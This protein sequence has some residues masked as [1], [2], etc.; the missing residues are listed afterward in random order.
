MESFILKFPPDTQFSDEEFFEFCVANDSLRIERNSQGQI[1]VMSPSGSKT[2]NLHFRIYN[3]L[4]RWYDNHENLG[5]LFDA[6]A[7][8]TL[9][10]NSVLAPDVAF[11]N[12]E[13]WESLTDAQQKKFAPLTP[14]FV[15]EVRSDSDS[16]SQLKS[17]MESW[18]RNG[19]QLA[20][21]IDPVEKKA[22]IY[23]P[24]EATLT[25]DNFNTVLVGEHVLPEFELFL[26]KLL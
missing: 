2:G 1:I 8:F 9:P 26:S 7:G 19:C 22:Y 25:V 6:S 13:R 12:K 15:I 23:K 20:W 18:I 17:K 3:A 5:Y 10:D 14:D 11:I 24:N 21:L 16:L 4:S